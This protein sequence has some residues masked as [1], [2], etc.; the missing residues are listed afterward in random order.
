MSH[1][2]D[3]YYPEGQSS[4][5][6]LSQWTC[7]A[8]ALEQACQ[9][10]PESIALT[11]MGADLSYRQFDRLASQFASYLQHSVGLKKGDRLALM[12]PNIM[13]LPIAFFAAQ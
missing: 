4:E 12:L 10:Y 6:N 3:K 7:V 9:R 5:I 2:W 8:D 11:C 13:Q 1:V